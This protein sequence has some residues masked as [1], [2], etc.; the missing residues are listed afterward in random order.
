VK[1]GH[2]GAIIDIARRQAT[3]CAARIGFGDRWRARAAGGKEDH[4][5]VLVLGLFGFI[6]GAIAG[7]MIGV[8][9]GLIW[10][11]VFQ[12][13]CFEGTCGRLVLF[14]FMPIGIVLG[15]LIGALTLGYFGARDPTDVRRDA[16]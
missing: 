15:G 7:G 10:T 4:M 16:N 9:L 6:F 8:G 11:G 3:A 2:F 1:R 5:K 12:T 14:T 13:S